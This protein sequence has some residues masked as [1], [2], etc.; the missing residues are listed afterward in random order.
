MSWLRAKRTME[1]TV[2]KYGAYARVLD[3]PQLVLEGLSHRVG[4]PLGI[5]LGCPLPS[6]PL[7]RLLRRQAGD[8]GF[9]GILI[10]Q[11]VQRKPA[12]L[13]DLDRAGERLGMAAEQPRHLIRGFQVAIG[14]P[15]AAE[16][17]VVDRNVVPN[18]GDDILQNAAARHM[19]QHVVGDDGR[20]TRP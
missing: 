5:A 14:M 6:K 4:H 8:R 19:K 9:V 7:Q 15:L 2:R 18:A 10:G 16:T 20:Y 17:G 13:C 12:A 3:Q 1:F 11:L